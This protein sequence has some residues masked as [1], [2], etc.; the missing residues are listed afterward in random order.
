INSFILASR[1]AFTGSIPTALEL[2]Y[3]M[4]FTSY[5][6]MLKVNFGIESL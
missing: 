6:G 5:A 4:Q 1:N 3:C 2:K